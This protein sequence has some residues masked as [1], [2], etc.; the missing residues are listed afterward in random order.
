MTEREKLIELIENAPQPFTY[1]SFADYLLANGVAIPV[2]CKD[3]KFGKNTILNGF[4]ECKI[5]KREL[6]TDFFC[7]FGEWKTE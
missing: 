5:L 7:G 3:C 4:I 1:G 2:R 6:R